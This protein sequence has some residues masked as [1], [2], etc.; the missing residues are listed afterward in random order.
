MTTN[1]ARTDTCPAP[2]DYCWSRRSGFNTRRRPVRSAVDAEKHGLVGQR[3]LRFAQASQCDDV[4]TEPAQCFDGWQGKVLVG[5]EARHGQ[6]RRFV[7]ADLPIDLVTMRT[8]VRPRVGEV[9][10]VQ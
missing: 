7:L 9:L 8:Y 6:L 3:L 1:N 2:S 10:G 5:E 4:V